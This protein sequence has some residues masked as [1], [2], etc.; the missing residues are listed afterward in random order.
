MWPP[1]KSLSRMLCE[2]AALKRGA[3]QAP[4]VEVGGFL[5]VSGVT[6][7][8]DGKI[9]STVQQDEK[10]VWTGAPTGMYRVRDVQILQDGEYV[11]LDLGAEYIPFEN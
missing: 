11:D 2:L 3:R 6:Y 7:E 5:H 4:D 10:Q 9:V 1:L 8:V